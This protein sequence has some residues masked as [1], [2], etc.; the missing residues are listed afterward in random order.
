[1][2]SLRNLVTG[3]ALLVLIFYIDA[4][5]FLLDASLNN[6]TP[7]QGTGIG[8]AVLIGSWVF[9]DVL[10][11]SPV[12]RKPM[13][14]ATIVFIFFS[15][16]TYALCQVFSGP[17]AFIHVGAAIG[18]VMVLNVMAVI[19]PSQKSLVR[20]MESGE[21][22]DAKL[23]IAG[24][25]RSRHN[26]YLTLP[27]LFIMIS[28]H[29]PSTFSGS[30]NWLILIGLGIVGVL[31]GTIS[32][33]ATCRGQSGGCQ[34]QPWSDYLELLY[35][36]RQ[37]LSWVQARRRCLH[38]TKCALSFTSAAQSAIPQRRFSRDFK[39]RQAA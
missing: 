6:L 19:I 37:L 25:T 7:W 1:M 38:W 22:P 21:S 33:S 26:N 28:S 18:T 20:A 34:Q 13:L 11:R 39:L 29:Y 35:S 17:R 27:V 14:L 15:V 4:R 9:Y 24:L 31:V 23:G 3:V 32:M 8:I 36:P 5:V 30:W 2:G 12:N 10:C 16:L